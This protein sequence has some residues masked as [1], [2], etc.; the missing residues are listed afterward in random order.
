LDRGTGH[1]LRRREYTWRPGSGKRPPIMACDPLAMPLDH[2]RLASNGE[3][4]SIFL[5]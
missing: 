4:Q 1:A 2:C 5:I 3:K